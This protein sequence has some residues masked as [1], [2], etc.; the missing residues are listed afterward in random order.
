[1]TSPLAGTE[2]VLDDD[3]YMQA[4]VDGEELRVWPCGLDGEEL[5]LHHQ[6]NLLALLLSQHRHVLDG[7]DRRV[8]AAV[9]GHPGASVVTLAEAAGYN[10]TS[11][12]SVSLS[13]LRRLGLV[14]AGNR[15][16]YSAGDD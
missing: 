6:R 5:R 8:L 10:G 4:A 12:V 7:A 3:D 9:E 14:D 16:R 13:R 11:T 2:W 15:A 1:M